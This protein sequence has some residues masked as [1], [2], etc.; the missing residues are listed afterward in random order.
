MKRRHNVVAT[1]KKVKSKT[2]VKK[3]GAKSKAQSQLKKKSKLQSKQ[4]TKKSIKK[5]PL[6]AKAATKKVAKKK[7]TQT[8]NVKKKTA[9]KKERTLAKKT[10]VKKNVQRTV[11]PKKGGVVKKNA[12]EKNN[13][14]ATSKKLIS[15]KLSGSLQTLFT[16]LDDRLVV[17]LIGK[18]NKTSGGIYIPDSSVASAQDRGEVLAVGRG[19]QDKKGRIQPMDVKVGDK[20]LFSEYAASKV[21]IEDQDLLILREQ[22]VFGIVE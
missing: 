5:T 2:V 21:N 9:K 3:S 20:I 18:S 7:A 6:R 12:P 4:K 8:K 11:A 13:L 16:P 17:K 14:T 22:D 1:K 15:K 19:H 10:S